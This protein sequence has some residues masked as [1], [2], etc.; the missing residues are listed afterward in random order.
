MTRTRLPFKSGLIGVA[1][2][3][4]VRGRLFLPSTA[5]HGIFANVFMLAQNNFDKVLDA[6]AKWCT[7]NQEYDRMTWAKIYVGAFTIDVGHDG[8]AGCPRIARQVHDKCMQVPFKAQEAQK[9][10]STRSHKSFFGF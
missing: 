4:A 2:G 5:V 1:D 9:L 8:R 7:F 3:T 10:F 6:T